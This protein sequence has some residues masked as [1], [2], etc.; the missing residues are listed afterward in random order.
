MLDHQRLT[1]IGKL[2]FMGANQIILNDTFAGLS[3]MYRAVQGE[4][5]KVGMPNPA[6]EEEY[7]K[8]FNELFN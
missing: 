7:I 6:N 1:G 3:L 8:A 2:E 5:D 4:E